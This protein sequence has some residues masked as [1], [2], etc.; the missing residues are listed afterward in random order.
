MSARWVVENCSHAYIKVQYP[1]NARKSFFPTSNTTCPGPGPGG[2]G[3][4]LGP[5]VSVLGRPSQTE[6]GDDKYARMR[7]N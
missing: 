4:S 3:A 1:F 7:H 2:G 5:R 6:D